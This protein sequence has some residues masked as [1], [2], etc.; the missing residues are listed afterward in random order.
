MP[1]NHDERIWRVGFR[2]ARGEL[3]RIR[4][5]WRLRHRANAGT[6]LAGDCGA[7]GQRLGWVKI[8][9]R[10]A[11]DRRPGKKSNARRR[12]AVIDNAVGRAGDAGDW[13]SVVE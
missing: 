5:H 7:S 13:R 11:L 2:L 1:A 12:N 3:A 10:K 8:R 4:M 9:E 6:R